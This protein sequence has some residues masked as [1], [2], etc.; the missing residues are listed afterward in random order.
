MV[1]HYLYIPH[2][3]HFYLAVYTIALNLKRLIKLKSQEKP[4]RNASVRLPL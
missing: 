2:D 4:G 3:L 1:Y